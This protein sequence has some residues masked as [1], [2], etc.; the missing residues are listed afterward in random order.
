M[1]AQPARLSEADHLL[2]TDAVAKAERH[3]DGEIVTI[4]TDRSDAYHDVALH[5]AVLAMLLVPAL[6]ALAP[7]AWIDGAAAMML[8]WNPE[9]TL[10]EAMLALF[11]LLAGAFLIVRLILA[12]MPLR[13]AL[14]PGA[15][16]SRRVQRRA[17]ALFRVGCERKTTG[18][19]GILLYVS[20]G[21]HRAEIIADAAIHTRV[22][23]DLWGEAMAVLIDEIRAGRPGIGMAKAVE[24]IGAVLAQCLPKSEADPN[25][26]CDRLIEL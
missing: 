6:I 17:L 13:L 1:N 8:G 15:T 22:D 4:V 18:R 20:L 5:Y 3:S 2:V 7:P 26:L 25:Q 11:A 14:T 12:Y 16:K 21:E 10:S 24:R 23:P 9:L 19:T